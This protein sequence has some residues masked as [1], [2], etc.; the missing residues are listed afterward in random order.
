MLNIEYA[1]KADGLELKAVMEQAVA[2]LP[3]KDW[4]VA[5]DIDFL[6]RHIEEEGYI[7]KGIVEQKI[8]AFLVVRYPKL[9]EDNLGYY[10]P[11]ITQEQLLKVAHMESVAVLPK[12][13]GYKFQKQ[14]LE[15]AEQIEENKDTIYLMATVHPE[16]IY[17]KRNFEQ[18]GY[19]CLLETKKYGGLKRCV[20]LKKVK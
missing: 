12:F 9:A 1:T 10:L 4:Y 17:S 6:E 7:L 18:Q 8:V 11:N 14:L 16:N 15:M 3:Q 2:V 19:S 5:D 20:L 13:R